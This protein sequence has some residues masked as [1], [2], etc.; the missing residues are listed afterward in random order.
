MVI[1][2]LSPRHAAEY[3]A[4]M[5]EAHAAHP[6]AFTSTVA[7]REKRSPA[8]WKARLSAG[9][10]AARLVLGAFEGSTLIGAVGL[11]FERREKARHKATLFGMY[12]RPPW[13]GRGIGRQLVLSALAHASER[14]GVTVIQLTVTEGN[15][16]AVALYESCG[17]IR[18]GVEPM[19]IA[20]GSEYLAKVYMWRR[21]EPRDKA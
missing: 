19:A 18:F 21:I 6:D 1:E 8:W 20:A 4:L 13:R 11:S 12:V 17:F 14:P 9:P 7:E 2:R 15:A 3:R 10:D 16:H 5:L